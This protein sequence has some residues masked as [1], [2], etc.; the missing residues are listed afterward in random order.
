[1]SLLGWLKRLFAPSAAQAVPVTV[2]RSD[3]P[4]WLKI[5]RGEVG[6]KEVS[7][8][9][10]HPRIVEYALSTH[11]DRVLAK[12]DETPWCSSFTNWCIEHAGYRGTK[13]AWARSW[14]SW[15]EVLK[16]PKRGCVVV[17]SRGAGSGHVGF[18]LKEVGDSVL[19][20]GGNQNNSVCEALYPKD[21]L[22]GY[23]WP[24]G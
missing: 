5:A 4:S 9:A 14:L 20:L 1:M 18:F 12:S 16:Q 3:E 8:D 19:V 10:A 6:V 22:L 24:K 21:R 11:L 7:G 2:E 23:R 13:S 15:G 17:F